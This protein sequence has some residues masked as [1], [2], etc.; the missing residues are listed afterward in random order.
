M[1]PPRRWQQAVELSVHHEYK[2]LKSYQP[3]LK[4]I[5]GEMLMIRQA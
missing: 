2:V 4:I 3:S 1:E 5:H